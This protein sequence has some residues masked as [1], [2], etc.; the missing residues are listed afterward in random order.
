MRTYR[1]LRCTM[2]TF[3]RPLLKPPRAQLDL[4]HAFFRACRWISDETQNHEKARNVWPSNYTGQLLAAG[5]HIRVLHQ[6]AS[7]VPCCIHP[8]LPLTRSSKPGSADKGT[9]FKQAYNISTNMPHSH[10]KHRIILVSS[11][12]LIVLYFT[13]STSEYRE[14]DT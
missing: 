6:S 9:F 5:L 7:T 11:L 12:C 8:V 10:N 14:H 2:L 1:P 4:P 13:P 3:A